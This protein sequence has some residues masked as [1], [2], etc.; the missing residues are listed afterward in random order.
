MAKDDFAIG[1]LRGLYGAGV[2]NP[3]VNRADRAQTLQEAYLRQAQDDRMERRGFVRPGEAEIVSSVPEGAVRV[4]G[5]MAP[6]DPS[7]MN[8]TAAFITNMLYPGSDIQAGG[9]SLR[10][11]Y[12]RDTD[13]NSPYNLG[14]A[15]TKSQIVKN[16]REP[17]EKISEYEK[18]VQRNRAKKVV[19]QPK[20]KKI[21]D[22]GLDN[23]DRM[24]KEAEDIKN[25]PSLSLAT[26]LSSP[27]AIATEGG[28]NIL[29]RIKT[30]LS[31]TGFNVLQEMRTNSPT[32]GALGQ[33]SEKEN[34]FLR[35]NLANLDRWQGTPDFVDA[36]DRI[37][38][39]ARGA[40]GR[41]QQAYDDFYSDLGTKT[42]SS[43]KKSDD[44]LGLR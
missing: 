27:F 32:G 22:S 28:R 30:L 43:K 36:L 14:R 18:I 42:S 20:E 31:K 6:N 11:A 25:H 23:L 37:I 38:D 21:L 10:G 39:Y 17:K 24:I 29:S 33:V 2:G 8:K 13:P 41:L 4:G 5:P 34:E 40:K 44:P 1:L 7:F 35:E 9:E 12:V 19:N 16:L 3:A 15:L 26:G